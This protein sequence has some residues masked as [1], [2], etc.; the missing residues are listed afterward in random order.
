MKSKSRKRVKSSKPKSSY[1]RKRRYNSR[2]K[3]RSKKLKSRARA[4]KQ[5][6]KSRP[7]RSRP[8]LI[9]KKDIKSHIFDYKIIEMEGCGYC[10]DAKNLILSKNYKLDVKK[11]MNLEEENEIKSKV[12]DYPF[13]PKIFKWDTIKKKYDFIGGYDKLRELIKSN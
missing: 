12:G 1:V 5:K 8:R 4:K 10:K 6:S 13:F 11:D 3:T 7:R 9:I 2:R